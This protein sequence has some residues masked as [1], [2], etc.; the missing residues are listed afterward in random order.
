MKNLAII[1]SGCGVFDGSEIHEA[2]LTM[3]AVDQLGASYTI[4]APDIEQ[5]HVIDHITGHEMLE[6]RNVLI[7]AS[8]IARGNILPLA[9]LDLATIDAILIPGGFGAAKNLSDFAVEGEAMKVLPLLEEILVKAHGK[10]LPIGAICIAPV[11]LANIFENSTVTI[12]KDEEAK[13]A[14]EK[15]GAHHKEASIAEISIDKANK[16]VTAP[17]YMLEASI[18]QIAENTHQVVKTVLDLTK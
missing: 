17:C 1:L 12:G 8:R 10:G 13:T 15:M 16:L 3:L 6:T 14:I 5:R 4:Y 11:I 7:E 2:V 9:A 18:S